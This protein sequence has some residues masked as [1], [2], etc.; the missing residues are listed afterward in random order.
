MLA[1]VS[2]RRFARTR[3]P[4]GEDVLAAERSTSKSAVVA[5]VRR[6]DPRAPPG[7]DVALACGYPLGGADAR[8]DRAEGPLLRRCAWASRP[9]GSRCRSGCGT[10]RRRTKPSPRTC[11]QTSSHRG[12]DVEQGVLVVLDGSKAF[13]AAVREVFGPVP[14]QRC[15]VTRNAGSS[16][17]CPSAT[18]PWS[19][20]AAPSVGQRRPRARARRPARPRLRARALTSRCR[21]PRCAKA[22]RR[23]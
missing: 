21:R 4:V 22:W 16:I 15:V 13:R 18:A 12:L 14:V 23:R 2:T 10:A 17:T 20:T 1:G 3:E 6:P 7:A 9:T 19:S 11:S 5:G 8:R